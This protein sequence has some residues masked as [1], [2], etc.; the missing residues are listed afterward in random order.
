MKSMIM[1][2]LYLG[3]ADDIMAPLLL[4]PE[5]TTLF[6]IDKFDHHFSKDK[7]WK[8]QKEDIKEILI[9]GSDMNSHTRQVNIKC[10]DY[11]TIHYLDGK[12]T[13]VEDIDNGSVWKLKFKY[14]NFERRLIYYHHRDFL[15]KWP[16]DIIDI[17]HIMMMGAFSWDSFD[18]KNS[19]I[20]ISM[21]E[22][23]AIPPYYL[24]A[25]SFNHT[26][27]PEHMY[28]DYYGKYKEERMVA[29][30]KIEDMSYKNWIEQIYD[31]DGIN[32]IQDTD[33]DTNY[34]TDSDD[35]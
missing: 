34:D 12:S 3:M 29:K 8:G 4:V 14:K 32:N 10:Y 27:F 25:L 18:T 1:N 30:I 5:L 6:V 15:I 24:Y 17:K 11:D 33:S 21:L 28:L 7:T 13:I 35:G 19:K 22:T 20:L 16:K 23:R 26:H 31:L 2:V 9:N